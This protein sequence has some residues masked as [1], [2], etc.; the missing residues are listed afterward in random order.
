MFRKP[1][2][3]LTSEELES[4]T[5]YGSYIRN[6]AAALGKK[7]INVDREIQLDLEKECV[8]D[9]ERYR[10]YVEN[11][12]KIPGTP[13][14]NFWE[15]VADKLEKDYFQVGPSVGLRRRGRWNL[16]E[17]GA[18]VLRVSRRF[19]AWIGAYRP[20]GWEDVAGSRGQEREGG[21]DRG[22]G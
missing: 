2:V 3:F 11:W 20:F 16:L 22:E 14:R 5:E 9:E 6:F 15:V 1:V 4:K 8:I 19:W 7:P 13:E 21:G 10:Q 18:G 12:I 17:R